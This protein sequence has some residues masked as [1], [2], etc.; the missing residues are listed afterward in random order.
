MF[1]IQVDW[2][3]LNHQKLWLSGTSTSAVPAISH[4][5]HSQGHIKGCC[6]Y[7]E[8]CRFHHTPWK[9]YD[10][11]FSPRHVATQPQ[12][13]PCIHHVGT[14]RINQQESTAPINDVNLVR[15]RFV[16]AVTSSNPTLIIQNEHNYTHE[17][18]ATYNIERRTYNLLHIGYGTLLI[19][20]CILHS[21]SYIYTTCCISHLTYH[22]LH[23]NVT[24]HI[25]HITH[26]IIYTTCCIIFNYMFSTYSTYYV[27]LHLH[28][29]VLGHID[30]HIQHVWIIGSP[31][32]SLGT[33]G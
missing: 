25:S 26:Y 18:T 31:Q 15:C 29:H 13:F 22:V 2:S 17:N 14:C 20:N 27:H 5:T 10:V 3:D 24:Y 1:S 19:A 7:H 8:D 28:G 32:A 12:W 11:S 4:L 6:T 30:P 16:Y 9:I 21:K 33:L 23:V